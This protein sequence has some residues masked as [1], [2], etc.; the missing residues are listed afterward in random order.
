MNVIILDK[1]FELN[2]K[3]NHFS[4]LLILTIPRKIIKVC[5]CVCVFPPDVF[6]YIKI[7]SKMQ[8]PDTF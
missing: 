4:R 5:A 3:N 2:Q 6:F 8:F 1:K 7:I